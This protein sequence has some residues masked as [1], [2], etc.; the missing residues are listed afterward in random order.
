[1]PGSSDTEPRSWTPTVLPGTSL[2]LDE[3]RAK[4][5]GWH[6]AKEALTATERDMLHVTEA[7]LRL[8]DT[9]HENGYAR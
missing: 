7:L 2:T 4:I 6:F 1:M 9:H 5:S 8:V 3:A